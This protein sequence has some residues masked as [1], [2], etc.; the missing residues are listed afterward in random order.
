MN[1]AESEADER[2]SKGE[3]KRH[4]EALQNLGEAL[5]ELPQS[6]LDALPLPE[7]LREAVALARRI[8][9]HGGLYR[10]KQYIG[11]LMRKID[12]EPIRQALQAKRERER[13]AALR[14]RRIE[15]YREQLL[16][17]GPTALDRIAP[18]LLEPQLAA[19]NTLIQRARREA[20]AGGPKHAGRELFRTLDELLGTISR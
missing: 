15:Q 5:I 20:A 13:H 18:G 12:A 4:S 16:Q 10:Q 11:K 7:P 17:E 19:L 9:K 8:T 3:R 6:E 2:P 14:F 1:E